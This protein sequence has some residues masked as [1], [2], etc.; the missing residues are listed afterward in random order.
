MV[1]A[2]T[3]KLNVQTFD[4]DKLILVPFGDIHMGSKGFNRDKFME[5]LEW[6][7]KV[8]NAYGLFMGDNIECA[9]RDSVGAGVYEQDEIVEEQVEDFIKTV[10]PL[11]DAGKV[12]GTH[13]GNHEWRVYKNSGLDLTNQ[14]AKRLGIKYFGWSVHHLLRVGDQSYTLFTT[15]GS[16]GSRL[17][18]TKI[19]AVLDRQNITD[20]DIYLMGHLHQL[21]HHTRTFYQVDKRSKTVVEGEKHFVLCGSYLEHWG[22]YAEQAGYEMMRMGSPKVKLGGLERRIKISL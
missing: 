15:H 3:Q 12:I 11:V 20:V 10:Q 16:G 1:K 5:D 7:E 18:H 14:M 6:T 2:G 21:S 8:P 9:T 22:G 17:P 4:L 19:K 13:T